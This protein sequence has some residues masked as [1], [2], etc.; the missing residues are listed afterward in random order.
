MDSN[1]NRSFG[2]GIIGLIAALLIAAF[3]GRLLADAYGVPFGLSGLLIWAGAL[4]A[5]FVLGVLYFTQFILP[6]R[7][8]QGWADGVSMLWRHY[9]L[10][11]ERFMSNLLGG[12]RQASGR[13]RGGSRKAAAMIRR[14]VPASFDVLDAGIL[15]SYQVLALA[16]GKGYSRAVGP[17]FVILSGGEKIAK[18]I[19]LR[20]HIRRQVV[21]A[22]TRDGIPVD[23]NMTV[24]FRVRQAPLDYADETLPHPYDK[25][26]IFH[27][28]YTSSIDVKN[29]LRPWQE[30]VHPRAAAMVGQEIGRY[31][32]D[33]LYQAEGGGTTLMDEMSRTIQARLDREMAAEGIEILQLRVDLVTL[34]EKVSAQRI[35]T[36]QAEWQRQIE[37]QMATVDAE[38]IR[39]LNSARARVQ[40]ELIQNITQNIEAMRRTSSADLSEIITLRMIEAMEEASGDATLR[41]L[42]PQPVIRNLMDA[43]SQMLTLINPSAEEEREENDS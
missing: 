36:W 10:A 9:N 23:T 8:N 35:K 28:S 31:S 13:G 33:A 24:V 43:S 19:D 14:E 41:A 6:V 2:V 34:P 32:L 30:Q 25:D 20:P 39:R 42:I 12:N 1:Q 37:R 15:Q 5:A 17:G 38:A 3:V 29:Q 22:N 40:I 11:G 18:V 7:G 16:K 4:V 27:I 21:R 26:A